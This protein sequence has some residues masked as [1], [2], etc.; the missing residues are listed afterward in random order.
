M[1][2]ISAPL[3]VPAIGPTPLAIV[4][5]FGLR[6]IRRK[7]TNHVP[8]SVLSGLSIKA[9]LDTSTYPTGIEVNDKE[10]AAVRLRAARFHGDWN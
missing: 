7:T 3:P 6:S 5:R 2:E 8:V 4:P 9:E 1:P 10:S